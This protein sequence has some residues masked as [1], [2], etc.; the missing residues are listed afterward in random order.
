MGTKALTAVAQRA[1][2]NRASAKK[3]LACAQDWRDILINQ[4]AQAIWN[5]LSLLVRSVASESSDTTDAL[6][7]ELFLFLLS[8]GK[9][10]MY[11]EQGLS[12]EEIRRD[13]LSL[14]KT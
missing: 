11:I 5:R 4:D 3:A 13:I 7:Q 12:S 14:L 8:T 10:D 6:A 2:R 1:S 9:F